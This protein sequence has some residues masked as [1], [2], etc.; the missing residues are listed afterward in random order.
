MQDEDG[1]GIEEY[2]ELI[3]NE[4]IIQLVKEKLGIWENYWYFMEKLEIS[5]E[6]I[7]CVFGDFSVP[8]FEH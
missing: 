5:I 8:L 7:F 6:V 2:A 3:E 1:T 4:D